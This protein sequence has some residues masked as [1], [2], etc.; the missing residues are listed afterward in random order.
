MRKDITVHI[1]FSDIADELHEQGSFKTLIPVT[2][3]FDSAGELVVEFE[4][5]EVEND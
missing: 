3:Y 1:P 4:G 2:V 5:E